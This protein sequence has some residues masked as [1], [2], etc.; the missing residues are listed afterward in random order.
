MKDKAQFGGQRFG[1]M[2]V[3][4]LEAYGAAYTLQ[5][6]LAV[7]SDDIVGRTKTYEAIVKGQNIPTPGVPESFKVMVKELQALCLDVRVLDAE[8]NDIDISG[9]YEDDAP[10]F[11]SIEEVERAADKPADSDEEDDG[12][13]DGEPEDGEY[14]DSDFD[15]DDFFGEEYEVDEDADDPLDED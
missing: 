4:A 15:D 1:E 3:W 2:E 6:I 12:D 11:A 13:Y 8:G 7:K 10:R 14:D 5:E 9:L